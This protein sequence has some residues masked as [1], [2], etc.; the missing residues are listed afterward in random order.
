MGI[1]EE[2]IDI[3]ALAVIDLQHYGGTATEAPD[4]RIANHSLG[5]PKYLGSDVEK[6]RPF[7][8]PSVVHGSGRQRQRVS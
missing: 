3:M 8:W 6:D 2:E 7:T 5:V 4:R 1:I